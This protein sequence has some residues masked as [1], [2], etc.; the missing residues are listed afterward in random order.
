MALVHD[1][2]SEPSNHINDVLHDLWHW[3]TTISSPKNELK[4]ITK[5]STIC[6]T[7]TPRSPPRATG[8][9]ATLSK[10][11]RTAARKRPYPNPAPS[12]NPLWG[13]RAPPQTDV[14]LTVVS[15]CTGLWGPRG[16]GSPFLEG[17]DTGRTSPPGNNSRESVAHN[18]LV[19]L[20]LQTPGATRN[21][22]P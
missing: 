15:L 3:H 18:G 2:L 13:S 17:G 5:T 8:T 19:S 7:G 16:R 22:D 4:P 20:H 12:G 10:S 21:G 6:G 9:S 1:L 11:C 14:V